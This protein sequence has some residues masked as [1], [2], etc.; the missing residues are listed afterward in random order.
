MAQALRAASPKIVSSITP[1]TSIV[2]N[3]IRVSAEVMKATEWVKIPRN[4]IQRNETLRAALHLKTLQPEHAVAFM[5]RDT[6]GNC[7]KVDGHTRSYLIDRK[8]SFL[9]ELLVIVYD[10]LDPKISLKAESER[11]YNSYDSRRSVKTSPD[12]IQGFMSAAGMNLKTS[13]LAKG[14]F[15]EAL[16]LASSYVKSAPGKN[17]RDSQLKFFQTELESLDQINPVSSRFKVPFLASALLMLRRDSGSS[18]LMMLEAFNDKTGAV[19]MN[20]QGNAHY[21]LNSYL[22]CGVNGDEDDTKTW[23]GKFGTGNGDAQRAMHKIITYMLKAVKNGNATLSCRP[24]LINLD[25]F[26]NSVK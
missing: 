1:A 25:N 19:L 18:T 26:K 22:Q 21:Y 3:N 13:W 16:T 20:G 7:V 9:D 6:N 17:D 14:S 4:S 11:L 5:A 12:A 23:N 8:A 24:K 10:I 15:G 2:I